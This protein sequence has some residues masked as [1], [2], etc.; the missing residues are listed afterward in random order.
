MTTTTIIWHIFLKYFLKKFIFPTWVTLFQKRKF[1]VFLDI[2]LD[3]SVLT[4]NPKRIL[5]SLPNFCSIR[6]WGFFCIIVYHYIPFIPYAHKIKFS[7]KSSS[8]K[9]F[10]KRVIFLIFVEGIFGDFLYTILKMSN[11]H[12]MINFLHFGAFFGQLLSML[13][14]FLIKF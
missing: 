5:H 12:E 14:E 8:R 10:Q 9:G 3:I 7:Q 4:M 2:Y 13:I 1:G 11:I 6:L